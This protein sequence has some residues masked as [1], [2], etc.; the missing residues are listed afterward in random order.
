MKTIFASALVAFALLLSQGLNAQQLVTSNTQRLLSYQGS[1]THKGIAVNGHHVVKVRLYNDPNGQ[2]LLWEDAFPIEIKDGIFS[3]MLGSIKQLPS[4][5]QLDGSIWLGIGIDDDKEL[6][7]LTPLASSVQALSVADGSITADKIATD[8]VGSITLDNQKLTGRGGKLNLASGPGTML[9]YDKE[10][11]T[12]TIASSLSIPSQ[13]IQTI[14][15]DPCTN[16]ADGGDTKNIVAGGCANS[17]TAT[18]ASGGFASILGGEGNNALGLHSTVGGGKSNTAGSSGSTHA[19]VTGGELNT[20][21]G[22]HSFIGGGEENNASAT[23]SAIGGGRNNQ[24]T[25]GDAFVGGGNTNQALSTSAT[26]GGGANNTVSNQ[27]STIGGGLQNNTLMTTKS[28]IGGGELHQITDDWSTIGGGSAN[29][30]GNNNPLPVANV[31]NP[32]INPSTFDAPF[33]TVGGGL[34]NYAGGFESSITGGEKNIAM[35]TTSSIIGGWMN[36]AVGGAST[37][38]GGEQNQIGVNTN[39]IT[40]NPAAAPTHTVMGGE[41]IVTTTTPNSARYAAILGGQQNIILQS[42]YSFIG[43]G[44][45]NAIG[46][47]GGMTFTASNAVIGGGLSNTITSSDAT[48]GGGNGNTV[49][50][51]G[52]FIGG[53]TGN[54]ISTGTDAIVVGGSGNSASGM[55]SAVGGGSSNGVSGTGSTIA[56]GESNSVSGNKSAIPG[57]RM[58]T[59]GDNS[60]GFNGDANISTT[61]TDL[62]A[63]SQV[64][65][66]GETEVWIGNV[67]NSPQPLLFFTANNDFDYSSAIATGFVA[68][69]SRS[70]TLVYTLPSDDPAQSGSFLMSDQNGNL[71]WDETINIQSQITGVLPVANGGTGQSSVAVG[72]LLVGAA[73]NTLSKLTIGNNNDF[74]KITNGSP[75]WAPITVSAINFATTTLTGTVPVPNGGTGLSAVTVGDLLVGAA[76]NTLSLLAVSTNNGDILQVVNGV[77]AWGT[78]SVSAINFG[79]TTLTGT[80]PVA[81]GGTGQ[82]T[83]TSGDLLVGGVTNTLT[84]LGIGANGDFLKVVNGALA[85]STA[86]VSAIN[87]ATA[88]LTSTVPVANGGTG[89]STVTAGDLLVGGANNT[90]TNL[91]KGASNDFLTING[92]GSLVWA[93]ATI[94]SIDYSTISGSGVVPIANG[95]TGLGTP[96]SADQVLMSNGSTAAWTDAAAIPNGKSLGEPKDGQADA[97]KI[98]DLTS[99]SNTIP[100]SLLNNTSYIKV[101]ANAKKVEPILGNSTSD[102]HWG[103]LLVVQYQGNSSTNN[104]VLF[105]TNNSSTQNIIVRKNRLLQEGNTITFIWDEDQALWVEIGFTD[106]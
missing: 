47:S 27:F 34:S 49:S 84:K 94:S 32:P 23:H 99:S 93:P 1:I 43:A 54:S 85:W 55:T 64:T 46:L 41:W 38:G 63:F 98:I 88:T 2:Q 12:L 6:R 68:P 103:Q 7:P 35:G 10:T 22:G 45:N 86:T 56:G 97:D 83:V 75:V 52:G 37:I 57:G 9:L 104:S 14:L 31:A 62:S 16:N 87:F 26:I 25:G 76:G 105:K 96:G 51:S 15:S 71:R 42:D 67:T 82:S 78:V 39:A 91:S 61:Q 48:I 24:A 58:L 44:N 65:Y 30:V 11:K 4:S 77:P 92:S 13:S 101:S 90:L 21:T 3:I 89:I 40:R 95:G 8:Y 36:I 50:S 79:T 66:F 73:N 18:T 53:G 74:L 70:T 29:T 60:F 106:K 81:N 100:S 69:S 102:L 20:A 19:G 59:L 5:S 80:V 33:G 17:A 72:D 28:F